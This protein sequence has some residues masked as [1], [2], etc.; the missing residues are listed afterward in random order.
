MH[1]IL[2]FVFH[3]FLASFNNRQGRGPE[4]QKFC[5]ISVKSSYIIVFS[6]IQCYHRKHTVSLRV[7]GENATFHSAYSPKTHNFASSLNTLYT[8]KSAQFYSAF[9]PTTTSLTPRFRRKREV[10]LRFF[11]ENAQ[12]D[13]KTHSCED[14]AKFNSAFSATTLSH[15]SRF[16]RKRRVIDNFECLSKFEEY[17]RKCWLYCV[18]YLLVTERCKKKFQNRL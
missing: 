7:F 5:Q 17:F 14:S 6:R 1:K 4:F 12:N 2:Q 9:S 10:W 18:L 15:A 11:A 16:R 8:A 13:P 3:N